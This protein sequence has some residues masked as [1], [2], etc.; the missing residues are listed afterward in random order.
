MSK[1]LITTIVLVFALAPAVGVSTALADPPPNRA[2]NGQGATGVCNMLNVFRSAV[3][4][5]GMDNSSHGNG[6]DNMANDLVIPA[7]FPE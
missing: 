7:C 5:T 4:I 3:G 2:D 1:K 6:Y